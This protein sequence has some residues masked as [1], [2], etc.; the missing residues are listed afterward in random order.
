MEARQDPLNYPIKLNNQIAALRGVVESADARPT[1]QAE[2]A[3]RFLSGQLDD[4][5]TRLQ[6]LFGDDL[7]E[8][9]DLLRELGLDP[10]VV[11]YLGE[12]TVS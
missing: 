3:L 9:N 4:E 12:A 2:E 8:L 11:P 7:A 6:V 10:I 1:N 5:L